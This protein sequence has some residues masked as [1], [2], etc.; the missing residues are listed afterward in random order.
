MD[1][2]IFFECRYVLIHIV[3]KDTMQTHKNL[4][5]ILVAL[6]IKQKIREGNNNKTHTIQRDRKRNK[7]SQI[8]EMKPVNQKTNKWRSGLM[9]SETINVHFQLFLKHSKDCVIVIDWCFVAVCLTCIITKICLIVFFAPYK[10]LPEVK[11]FWFYLKFLLLGFDN[12]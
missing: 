7:V 1:G 5:E 2:W 4:L 8:R 6:G 3:D 9:K 11:S 10:S 12:L